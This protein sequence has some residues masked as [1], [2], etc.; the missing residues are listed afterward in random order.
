MLKKYLILI[1]LGLLSQSVKAQIKQDIPLNIKLIKQ[2]LVAT[3]KKINILLNPKDSLQDL[4]IFKSVDVQIPN[5]TVP[6]KAYRLLKPVISNKIFFEQA[7]KIFVGLNTFS[8]DT[9]TVKVLEIRN[10][11]KS[12]RIL[13]DAQF[14]GL[15]N[16]ESKRQKINE[17]QEWLCSYNNTTSNFEIESIKSNKTLV[18]NP[19]KILEVET[20]QGNLQ[21]CLIPMIWSENSPTQKEQALANWKKLGGSDSILVN[22]GNK[23]PVKVLLKTLMNKVF[24]RDD[25]ANIIINGIDLEQ[26]EAPSLNKDG[27]YIS[28]VILWKGL[29]FNADSA[30]WYQ[31]KQEIYRPV[32]AKQEPTLVITIVSIKYP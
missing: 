21:N 22:Q 32:G 16:V 27:S 1:N 31:S 11:V 5:Y 19:L 7:H 8:I 3:E 18:V 2:Y 9:S 29:Y 13:V 6:E 17:T 26:I 4:R 14:V 15:L 30:Q 28:R 25:V 10:T 23:P 12:F 20:L 24:S